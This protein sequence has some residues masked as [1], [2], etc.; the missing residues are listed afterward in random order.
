MG[1]RFYIYIMSN[2]SKTLYIGVTNNLKRR[3]FEHKSKLIE[4]FTRTYNITQLVYFEQISDARNSIIR[5]KQLKGWLR[6]KKVA[7]IEGLNPKW[8]DL[9]ENLFNYKQSDP[10]SRLGRDS[11]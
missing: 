10:S 1:K 9:S 5:E 6:S 3:I 8:E 4:G 2:K 7:L 11:G